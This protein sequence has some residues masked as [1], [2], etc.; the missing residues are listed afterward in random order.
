VGVRRRLGALAAQLLQ[1][2]ATRCGA[3]TIVDLS[4]TLRQRQRERL[5]PFG[6]RVRWLDACPTT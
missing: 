2:L 6:D 5:A 1:A 4:G 3:T